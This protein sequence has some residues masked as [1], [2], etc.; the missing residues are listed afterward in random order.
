[1]R[2]RTLLVLLLSLALVP[3]AAFAQKKNKKAAAAPAAASSGLEG[4]DSGAVYATFENFK[5]KADA[6]MAN[7]DDPAELASLFV[8]AMVARTIDKEYGEALMGYIVDDKYRKADGGSPSGF[9]INSVFQREM[10]EPDKKPRI[11]WAYCGGTIKG[12]YEDYSFANCEPNLDRDYSSK[13]QG[14][15]SG[16]AK[17][18]VTNNGAARPRPVNLK[19]AEDGSWRVETVSGLMTGI[20]ATATETAAKEAERAKE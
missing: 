17:Y 4:V 10:S 13:M 8:Q 3:S 5:T 16:R 15:R 18:F 19:Q 7:K 1:M 20:A 6:A 2:I 12:D 11:L 9:V 14:P